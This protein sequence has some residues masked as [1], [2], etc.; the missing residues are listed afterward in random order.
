MKTLLK[1]M[2]IFLGLLIT[3]LLP[4]ILSLVLLNSPNGV[5]LFD[6]LTFILIYLLIAYA[7]YLACR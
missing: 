7:T 2:T 3:V 1:Q 5:S 6:S 4:S